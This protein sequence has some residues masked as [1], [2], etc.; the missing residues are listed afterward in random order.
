MLNLPA[1]DKVYP[2]ARFVVTHRDVAASIPSISALIAAIG[3]L[4]AE[5]A[6]ARVIGIGN[7]R[8]WQRALDRMESF[9]NAQSKERFYDIGFRALQANPIG[10]VRDLYGWLGEPLTPEFERRMHSWLEGHARQTPVDA[11]IDPRRFG[12]EPD[13][14]RRDNARY[15]DRY[16]AFV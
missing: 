9:R 7:A 14:L 2:D 1:L 15:L 8:L 6:D 13:Q 10:A 4:F 3:G 12:L 16:R 11:K 5:D